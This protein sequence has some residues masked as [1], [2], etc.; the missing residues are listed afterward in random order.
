MRLHILYIYRSK[1]RPAPSGRREGLTLLPA[2]ETCQASV[3]WRAWESPKPLA[4]ARGEKGPE[5]G[6]GLFRVKGTGL[7]RCNCCVQSG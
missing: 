5:K 2:E 6:T 1:S 3:M 7:F 4:R